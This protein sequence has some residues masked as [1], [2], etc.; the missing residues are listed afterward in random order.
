MNK[1]WNY[2]ILVIIA[3]TL[4]ACQPGN[5]AATQTVQSAAAPQAVIVQGRLEPVNSIDL[6]FSTNGRVAEVLV[7]EG[8]QITA[9]QVIA[10]LDG[11][12]SR[13]ADLA[14]AG[15][16][17]AAAEQALKDLENAA[18]L[19]TVQAEMDIVEALKTVD[20]IQETVDDLA[21]QYSPDPKEVNEA[22]I[23]LTLAQVQLQTAK[24]HA[25]LL[26]DGVDP[27]ARAAANNRRD[28]AKASVT[29]AQ[30][31]LDAL[32]LRAP[33]A[34]TLVGLDLQAGQFAAAGQSVGTVADF[35]SWVIQ[36]DDLTELE[37]VRVS[38][39]ESASLIL[40]ALP[41]SEMKAEV[42]HIAQRFEEKR[43]DVTYTVTL[44][45]KD[46]VEALRWGMTGQISFLGSE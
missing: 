19:N 16:E 1:R 14:R 45:I 24:D 25:A 32:D 40:D 7:K 23:R 35:S 26:K 12:E 4:A 22:K 13:L 37:V 3:L 2:A 36:T 21:A 43:G 10:R 33:L 8:D 5:A 27:D 11:Q 28:T 42:V 18:E 38:S 31:A 6:A 34:G 41:G 15:Q 46:P 39:G 29:A 30:A 20:S 44:A 17:L 9:G